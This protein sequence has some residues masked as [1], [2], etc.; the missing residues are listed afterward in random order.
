MQNDEQPRIAEAAPRRTWSRPKLS[1]I[2]AGEAELGANPI[3]PEGA[4]A[5]GS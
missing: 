2:R 5:T 4:F 3:K 1:R